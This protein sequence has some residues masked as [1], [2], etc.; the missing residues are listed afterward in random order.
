MK[1][2]INAFGCV[3]FLLL[4]RTKVRRTCH[5][6]G[7]TNPVP[8]KYLIPFFIFPGF[9]GTILKY[10]LHTSPTALTSQPNNF[11]LYSRDDPK[12]RY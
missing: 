8:T 4:K 1:I 5:F 10:S 12:G 9:P 11:V 7:Q 3:P 2:N 6:P